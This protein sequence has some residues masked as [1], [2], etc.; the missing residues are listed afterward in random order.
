MGAKRVEDKLIRWIEQISPAKRKRWAL[1]LLVFCCVA[2]PVCQV[3]AALGVI[4]AEVVQAII[5]G[6]SWF[7]IILTAGDVVLTTD[8]RDTQEGS[9]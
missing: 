9:S 8:V 6:L 7:A 5:Q 1:R 3:A 2:W 4:G